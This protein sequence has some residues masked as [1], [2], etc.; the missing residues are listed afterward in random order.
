MSWTIGVDI[1]GTFTDIVVVGDRGEQVQWKQDSTPH[2]LSEAIELGLEAVAGELG[3]SLRELLTGTTS[4]VHGS[5]VA[6]NT[7]IERNGPRVGLVCTAGFRDALYFRDGFK[8]DRF[9]LALPRPDDFVPRY[10]RLG[11]RERVLA[12]GS[13]ELPLD[14][15]SVAEVA[16]TFAHHGV[17]SVA[18]ALLWSHVDPAHERRVREVLAERLPGIPVM[19]SSEILP[20]IGEWTRTSATVLSA[21]AYPRTATYLEELA[22]WLAANGLD[23]SLQVMQING[24]CAEVA[25]ALRVPVNLV[26]SGPAAAPAAS[27]HIAAR[28]G[29]ANALTIDMGGTSFEAGIMRDGEISLSRSEMIAFQPLG[30]AGV[31]I[32]SI[33]AGG[34]SIAWVD[35]GGALRVGPQS[36]GA[37]PGPAAYD[38]GGES[39]TVTDANIVLGYLSTDAFLGGRRRLRGDLARAAIETHVARPLGL[40][41]PVVAAAGV[42]RVVE[43]NMVS[44]IRAVTVERGIDPR[45]FA[46]ISGGGAGSLHAARLAAALDIPRVVIPAQAGTLSAFGMTVTDMRHDHTA[47]L[48]ATTRDLDTTAVGA[49]LTDLEERAL[50]DLR[51][52]GFADEDVRLERTVDARYAGQIHELITPVPAGQFDD[53]AVREL[54]E[55]FHGM[56]RERFTYALEAAPI[57]LLHWRVSG[58]GRRAQGEA[59]PLAMTGGGDPAPASRGTRRAYLLEQGEFADVPVYASEA[60]AP[61]AEVAGPAI[62]D[63]ATTTILVPAGHRLVGDGVQTYVMERV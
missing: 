19:L 8:P 41:D 29:L 55:S 11:V 60:L 46:L 37:S 51:A 62:L 24:G 1:G 25:Q 15:N 22:S 33:G 61:G 32:R 58:I 12:D 48:F 27:R 34:G 9:N 28:A 10:L 17:E 53:E 54:A 39:P 6:T 38:Q 31:E 43:E 16:R 52:S 5:T 44:A 59:A 21:Y 36:A 20:E 23:G 35:D 13:I 42:I 45:S 2:R 7:L 4:F 63:G 50:Q 47:A 40:G 49:V 3:V 57:E 14:E 18:V 56:H 26:H 30:V